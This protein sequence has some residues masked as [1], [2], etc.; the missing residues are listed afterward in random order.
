MVQYIK[1]KFKT[2]KSPEIIIYSRGR[3]KEFNLTYKSCL[4]SP[5]KSELASSNSMI[6]EAIEVLTISIEDYLF[7]YNEYDGFTYG[8]FLSI[9]DSII[10]ELK[11][12]DNA[13]LSEISIGIHHTNSYDS[14][15]LIN[16]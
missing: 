15:K 2:V 14:H 4:N 3:F 12:L 13:I 16:S 10:K 11:I 6:S 7:S 5:S 9:I 1:L 8:V